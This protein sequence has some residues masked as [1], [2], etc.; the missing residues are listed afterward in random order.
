MNIGATAT[1]SE[2]EFY[3]LMRD[4]VKPGLSKIKGVA[5]VTLVGGI[6]KEI[7]VN[8]Q[9]D[10]LEQ[11]HVSILQIVK[12]IREANLEFPTGKIKNDD[13]QILIKLAGQFNSLDE[14][15]E[16]VIT[17]SPMTGAPI[18]LYELAEV[19]EGDKE[20]DD[21]SRVDG[22]NAI[23][24][25]IQKQGDANAVELSRLVR[26]ELATLEE[27]FNN[28]GL[29]FKVSNDTSEFTLEAVKAVT[30]DIILAV[31][32][33][34]VVMLLFLQSF[35]NALIVMLSIPISVVCTFIGMYIFDFSFNLMT[36]LGITLVV[37]ILV[38]DSIVVL[39]N[40]YRHLEMEKEKRQAALEGSREIFLAALSITLVLVVV[41]FPLALTTGIVGSIMRQFA[42]VVVFS[43]LLSLL[44]SYT[45]TPSLASRFSK[46]QEF[47]R[48]SLW[49]SL[50]QFFRT[51]DQD[52]DLLVF[53]APQLVTAQ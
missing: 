4:R 42:L 30:N 33:V 13:Q 29:H 46:L 1:L 9:K 32:L 23:G 22:N 8:V 45:V 24:I 53:Q 20:I 10:R 27:Q 2:D 26:K 16:L 49:G 19:I 3:L 50:F 21:L 43:T 7:K 51:T 25:L 52:T 40:I 41:F 38:D 15:R 14:L 17:N 5:Q 6:E 39:E 36:L 31:I 11:L 12:A 48:Q 47:D 34:A 28:E 44:V 18:R 35:R 37:G